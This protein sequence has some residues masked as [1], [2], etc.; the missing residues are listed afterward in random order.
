MIWIDHVLYRVADLERAAA[1]FRDDYGLI[2]APGG[3]HPDGTANWI[4]QLEPPQY[5]ELIAVSDPAL[6][7]TT[8]R[9]RWM[10]DR[11]SR[12]DGWL[13]WSVGTDDIERESAR[14]GRPVVFG[15][16]EEHGRSGTWRNVFAAGADAAWLPFFTQYD[17]DPEESLRVRRR[18]LLEAAHPVAPAGIVWIETGGDVARVREWLGG[19]VLPVRAVDGPLGLR[20]VAIHTP[21]G[22]LVIR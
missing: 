17:G 6:A 19:D 1:R 14:L 5:V 11:I 21:G 13:A 4:I 3:V 8:P 18:A 7:I 22:E 10:V 2:A 9:G 20:A 12:G 15:E 16:I